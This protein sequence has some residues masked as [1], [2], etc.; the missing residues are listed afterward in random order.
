MNQGGNAMKKMNDLNISGIIAPVL[1]AFDKS[2]NFDEKAQRE[3]VSFLAGKVQGLY[4]CGT[5]GSGVLM[6]VA[7]RKRVAEVIIDEVTGRIPVIVHVGG[8]STKSV[9]ELAE[10]A[11]KAGATAVAA[12]PPIYYRFEEPEVERYFRAILEAVSVP[13][14]VYNNPQT[15]GVSVTAKFLA[16]LVD[17]GIK[18]VKDSSFN[19][20]V[21]YEYLRTVKNKNFIPIIGT[22]SLILPAVV[23]GAH[24]SVSGLANAIPEP[25]VELYEASTERNLE[26]AQKLQADVSTMRDIMHLAP[27]LPMI[28]AIL[29]ERGINAGYPRSPFALPEKEL[30]KKAVSELKKMG[31][32]F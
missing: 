29:R 17:L 18:G 26:K 8:A 28:Q 31:V 11:E 23:M 9:V 21:F 4:P 10:H 27:T 14:F 22:E 7:E 19:I 6:D 32:Q 2:G 24:G 5:Y 12:V 13:V 3:I 15:T 16:R 30:M 1:T 20:L 25:V